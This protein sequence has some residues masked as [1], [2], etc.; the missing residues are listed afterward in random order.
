[1][2]KLEQNT[3]RFLDNFSAGTRG[4]ASAEYFLKTGKYAVIFLHRLR[5]LE[6]YERHFK[7][8]SILDMVN[9][10]PEIDLKDKFK[11]DY[12]Q[13]LRDYQQKHDFLLKVDF[14]TVSDYLTLLKYISIKLSVLERKALVYLAAAVSDFY[15][16]KSE[17]PVHKIQSSIG[18]LNI[19]LKQVPKMLGCLSS[20]WCKNAFI[21]SFKLETD[22]SILFTKCKQSLLKYKHKLVIGNIL[23]ERKSKVYIL[24][25]DQIDHFDEIRLT[26]SEFGV[27]DEIETHIVDYLVRLHDEFV[28]KY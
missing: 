16:P 25:N 7:Q 12:S 15:L 5:S 4:A 20:D 18:A 28:V 13:V 11:H 6:P 24:K 27:V 2:V 3:V 21:V 1:M 23:N 14:Q 9:V 10:G 22:S 8:M 26:L 19:N 17:I